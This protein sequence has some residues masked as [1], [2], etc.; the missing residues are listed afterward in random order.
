M[1]LQLQNNRSIQ[2]LLILTVCGVE[3]EFTNSYHQSKVKVS[4]EYTLKKYSL[5]S[6]SVYIRYECFKLREWVFQK[7]IIKRSDFEL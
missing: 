2:F 5:I 4:F 6:D 3:Q 7:L 1:V